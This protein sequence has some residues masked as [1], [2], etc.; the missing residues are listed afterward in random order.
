M[1]LFCNVKFFKIN[2]YILF[3]IIIKNIVNYYNIGEKIFDMYYY[4]KI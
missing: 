4:E 1:M 2:W 3:S